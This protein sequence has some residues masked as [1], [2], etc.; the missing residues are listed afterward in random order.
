[1]SY[2]CWSFQFVAFN[3]FCFWRP[4]VCRFGKSYS[5]S[6]NQILAFGYPQ[7]QSLVLNISDLHFL[8]FLLESLPRVAHIGQTYGRSCLA[9]PRI[10]LLE[11][12]N[13][14]LGASN[15]LIL[16]LSIPVLVLRA[17]KNRISA[18]VLLFRGIGFRYLWLYLQLFRL[19]IERKLTK[20]Y[21]LAWRSITAR[22]QF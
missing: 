1:M 18:G 11:T 4:L 2:F 3:R 21:V 20:S 19:P 5:L 13:K 15:P 10:R 9:K 17:F 16:L 22:F 14:H 6:L 7:F 12:Y 8:L